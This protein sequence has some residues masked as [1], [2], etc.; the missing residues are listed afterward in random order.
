MAELYRRMGE[1]TGRQ[2]TPFWQSQ[3]VRPDLAS[4]LWEWFE[5]LMLTD[6]L[7]RGPLDPP[8]GC[9]SVGIVYGVRARRARR[10]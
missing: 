9:E 8:E 10:R 6:G 3:A 4:P 2:P 7:D 1:V 5:A